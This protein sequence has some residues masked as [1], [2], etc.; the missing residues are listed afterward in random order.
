MSKIERLS[1]RVAKLLSAAVHEVLEAV[2]ETVSEYQEKTAR[3]QRENESLKRRLLELQGRVTA[4]GQDDKPAPPAA[5]LAKI[6][7]DEPS[8][9]AER[10]HDSESKATSHQTLKAEQRMKECSSEELDC[11]ETVESRISRGTEVPTEFPDRLANPP[12]SALAVCMTHSLADT[13][14]HNSLEESKSIVSPAVSPRTPPQPSVKTEP[15]QME[16]SPSDERVIHSDLFPCGEM[17]SRLAPHDS[18]PESMPDQADIP[19]LVHYINADGLSSFVDSFPFECHPELVPSMARFG[20]A[21]SRQGESH[22]C[23]MCGKTFNRIGNLRIHQRCHT[24]ERPYC[25]LHCGKCFSHAG[26]LQKHTRVHTGE[27][28]YACLQCGKTFS[29]SSHLKKHQKIH[30]ERR[31]GE[32]FGMSKIERLNARVAKLLSAAVHE[33]LEVVKETVSEYQEKTARTQRENESLKRRLQEL[34]DKIRRESTSPL[35]AAVLTPTEN[36]EEKN[37]EPEQ[38]T[39]LPL[40][41]NSQLP[42]REP[43]LTGSHHLGLDIKQESSEHEAGDAAKCGLAQTLTECGQVQLEEILTNTEEEDVMAGDS[44]PSV[45][46][47][48]N[49]DTPNDAEASQSDPSLHVNMAVIKREPELT[50]STAPELPVVQEVYNDCVDLSSNSSRHMAESQRSRVSVGPHGRFFL[51]PNHNMAPIRKYGFAKTSRT[52]FDGKRT[53]WE[54]VRRDEAHMC[55][56]CGKTF[57]RVGN[58]RVHQRCHTGEKP[59]GCLQ[60]GRCFSQAGDLKKHKRVHTGEK[61]YYC[62]HCGKSFSRGENLKRHQKIHVGEAMQLQQAGSG[63]K[64]LPVISSMYQ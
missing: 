5:S 9:E 34:Q 42:T 36:A 41:Q 35:S 57:S 43:T 16:F 7:K 13:D 59:Y 38:D 30:L 64:E 61:P 54:Q 6:T 26:N 33:V 18:G 25:C 63:G 44:S 31:D 37:G 49:T 62:S 12:S 39:S 40:G 20:S 8:P 52:V 19:G 55:F 21:S 60:C 50:D 56:V 28:P 14:K 29:Q 4:A 32:S 2:K 17:E 45:K 23:I 47:D 10:G 51:H 22:S 15:E 3:T 53:R 46:T 1:A 11:L 58:L 27:R 24:G 48:I